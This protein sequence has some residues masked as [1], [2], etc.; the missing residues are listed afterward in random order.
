[1]SGHASRWPRAVEGA[2]GTCA[3]TPAPQWIADVMTDIRNAKSYGAEERVHR[4]TGIPVGSIQDQLSTAPRH[5]PGLTVFMET[6]AD[7]QATNPAEALRIFRRV[8]ERFG[9]VVTEHADEHEGEPLQLLARSMAGVG[10][11]A[12]KLALALADGDIDSDERAVI[13]GAIVATISRLTDLLGSV[14]SR[15]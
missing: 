7:V 15:S 11:V 6:L 1:V 4:R 12:G 3:T 10:D 8:A 5:R 13:R 9:Y 2:I 14:G